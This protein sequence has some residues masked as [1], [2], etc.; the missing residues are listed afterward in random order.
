MK[1]KQ[2]ILLSFLLVRFISALG[3]QILLFAVPL[4][5]Y[6]ITGSIALSGL[7]FFIEWVPRLISLPLAGAFSDKLGGINVY[8]FSDGMR[9]MVCAVAFMLTLSFPQHAFLIISVLMG[10]C[11]FFYAQSFISLEASIPVLV[12]KEN[13]ARAQSLLQGIE[14][15]ALIF[16]PLL[17]SLLLLMIPIKGLLLF[18]GL[19]FLLSFIGI[20]FIKKNNTTLHTLLSKKVIKT[21][22]LKDMHHGLSIFFKNKKIVLLS[23]LTIMINLIWGLCLSTTAALITGFYHLDTEIYGIFQTSAGIVVVIL[24][25]GLSFIIKRF[26]TFSIGVSA[27]G[28]MIV[29]GLVIALGLNTHSIYLFAMGFM[30]VMSFDSAFNVYIRSERVHLIPEQ[31]LGKTIG[32]IVLINQLS[33][34]LAG[35]LVSTLSKTLGMP[36][37]FTLVSLLALG[38]ITVVFGKL[39][40]T[41]KEENVCECIPSQKNVI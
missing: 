37:L 1:T 25:I 17:S 14:Q 12:G 34:P 32:V 13:V 38:L 6:K 33:L 4:L 40:P 31:D 26:S 20:F 11:A 16:G 27:Y 28:L 23:L 15:S 7:A 19:C 5:V 10:V 36:I 29:G 2:P 22:L 21:P 18:A 9:T 3:D 24:S 35:L 39:K 41:L 8:L 30:M